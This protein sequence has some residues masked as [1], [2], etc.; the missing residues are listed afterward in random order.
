MTSPLRPISH[1][2]KDIVR[3]VSTLFPVPGEKKSKNQLKFSRMQFLQVACA[4]LEKTC[5]WKSSG[6]LLTTRDICKH[7]SVISGEYLMR[8]LP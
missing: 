7:P 2:Q 4:F 8:S 3:V 5:I 6:N 1:L